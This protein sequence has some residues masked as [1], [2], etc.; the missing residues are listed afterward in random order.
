VKLRTPAIGIPFIAVSFISDVA[1]QKQPRTK[2][3]AHKKAQD[4]LSSGGRQVFTENGPAYVSS[5]EHFS[6]GTAEPIAL[7]VKGV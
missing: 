2:R 4:T 1:V 6:A 5:A 3:A 7:A